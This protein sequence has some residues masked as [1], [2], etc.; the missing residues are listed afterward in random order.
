[1]LTFG[2][3][4]IVRL[5][6]YAHTCPFGAPSQFVWFQFLLSCEGRRPGCI[7]VLAFIYELGR[8][9]LGGQHQ[10]KQ[11]VCACVCFTFLCCLSVLSKVGCHRL[12]R[13]C[14]WK[15]STTPASR[16]PGMPWKSRRCQIRWHLLNSLDVLGDS[17]WVVELSP[18]AWVCFGCLS[19]GD[20]IY[21]CAKGLTNQGPFNQSNND[22]RW[23]VS[24]LA[25]SNVGRSIS[26]LC[27]AALKTWVQLPAL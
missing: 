6:K 24:C 15:R 13:R 2:R 7:W 25:H 11:C 22:I 12:A 1:M 14:W 20:W 18:F 4:K 8:C 3:R 16:C 23:T 10:K 27:P 21:V 9:P 5:L 17:F 26:L 19:L